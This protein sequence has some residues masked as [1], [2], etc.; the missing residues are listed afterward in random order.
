MT[1]WTGSSA[2]LLALDNR[3]GVDTG[4]PPSIKKARAI[5]HE[6]A[7]RGVLAHRIDRR[8]GMAPCKRGDLGA[9]GQKKA[10][11]AHQQTR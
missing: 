1:C 6:T 2:L 7:R 3:T 10:V 8:N 4:L 9:V 5:A 11:T